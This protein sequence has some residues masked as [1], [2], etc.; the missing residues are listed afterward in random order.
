MKKLSILLIFS[1]YLFNPVFVGAVSDYNKINY[2]S[3]ICAVENDDLRSIQ[4]LSNQDKLLFTEKEQ[5]QQIITKIKRA[6][7]ICREKISKTDNIDLSYP[8]LNTNETDA[9]FML[10][11][12]QENNSHY[13]N[14]LLFTEEEMKN[15]GYKNE[16]EIK[17]LINAVNT[18]IKK[19]SFLCK[20]KQ[21]LSEPTFPANSENLSSL[22]NYFKNQ[23]ATIAN[24][25]GNTL[26]FIDLFKKIQA[27]ISLP[28]KEFIINH[29]E[30]TWEQFSPLVENIYFDESGI[31][32]QNERFIS[33]EEKNFNISWPEFNFKINRQGNITKIISGENRIDIQTGFKIDK[34]SITIKEKNITAALQDFF[35]QNKEN[36]G[37]FQI[38]LDEEE[39]PLLQGTLKKKTHFLGI[40]H[41]NMPV[42]QNYFLSGNKFIIQ[43]QKQPWWHFLAF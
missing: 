29:E 8:I 33:N 21:T 4:I 40:F 28:I 12:L 16:V 32:F 25:T 6:K 13:L 43:N 41:V 18:E 9:C 42:K 10:D 31:Y 7:Q 26:I 19:V 35:Q 34:Q 38:F 39:S 11:T 37:D 1:F 27:D 22:T 20:T 15:K 30:I 23:V 36:K 2:K 3:S 14:I 24:K 17:S 5:L